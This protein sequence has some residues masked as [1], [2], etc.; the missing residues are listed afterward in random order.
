MTG[1][2]TCTRPC[3]SR[4]AQT[5]LEQHPVSSTEERPRMRHDLGLRRM[6]RRFN[7]DDAILQEGMV[8]ADMPGQF[9]NMSS[10]LGAVGW[11]NAC[12]YVST[13]HALI[14]LTKTA[15]MEYAGHNIR[16]NA[17]GPA[18]ID[19]PLLTKNLDAETVGRLA[20]LHPIGRLGAPEEVSAMTCFLLSAN[21]SFITGSCH[22]VD[23]GYTAK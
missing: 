6:I 11:E 2:V 3:A 10:I 23:G 9:V 22:L 20:A 19:T 18:F 15:A 21:D 8:V 12:A 17:V 7:A 1:F 14:G 4:P 5:D 13:N 16:I